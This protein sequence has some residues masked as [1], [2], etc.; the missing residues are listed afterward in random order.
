MGR[1][2][3]WKW[4]HL[5]NLID[6]KC[7]LHP[8]SVAWHCRLTGLDMT[9]TLSAQEASDDQS[10]GSTLGWQLAALSQYSLQIIQAMTGI[11]VWGLL[12][13]PVYGMGFTLAVI[14]VSH[15]RWGEFAKHL[16]ELVDDSNVLLDPLVGPLETRGHWYPRHLHWGDV[17]SWVDKGL[18]NRM[19]W[20][21][22]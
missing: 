10:C 2:P 17:H 22:L 16:G 3:L 8:N 11:M 5:S 20:E 12:I 14:S 21:M 6:P 9:W 1:Q 15:G 7:S 13:G 18:R 19:P 4:D